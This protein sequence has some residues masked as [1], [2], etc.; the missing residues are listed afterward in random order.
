MSKRD[1]HAGE[2]DRWVGPLVQFICGA[3]FGAILGWC[4]WIF[5]LPEL[6]MGWVC[7]PTGAL[8]LGLVAAI[9]GDSMW[10]RLLAALGNVM[11]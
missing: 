5:A 4:V 6:D 2:P 8:V 3:V 10:H 1:A 9:W 7:V 11:E